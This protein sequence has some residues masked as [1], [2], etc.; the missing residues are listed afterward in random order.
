MPGAMRDASG[1]MGFGVLRYSPNPIVCVIDPEHVGLDAKDVTGIPRSCPV[2]ATVDDACRLGA[3]VFLLGIAPPGG[4]IPADWYREINQAWD[5]GMSIINGLHDR[6]APRFSETGGESNQW[7]WDI[8]TE[9]EGL[10]PNTGAAAGLAPKRVL[11]IGTDMAVGK[12]TAGLE[13][14]AEARKQ[15]VKA[16]FVATGQIGI[17][18]M[19]SGVPLDAIRVDFASGS[20]EGEMMRYPD[21]D[22]I[23]VEGQ[24]SLI[25]P[26]SSATLPLIR[27]S[28]P[29]HLILCAR[30]GQTHLARNDS[31]KIPPLREF[32]TMYEDLAEACNTFARPKTIAIA[33][34]CGHL[35]DAEADR[36]T[37]EI[38]AETGLPTTD[39]VR[40]GAGRLLEALQD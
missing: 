24:G 30:A 21:A 37:Q 13:L 9:P 1:K 29:T 39:P 36:A 28:M 16:E 15:N 18:I 4:L 31:I 11:F 10:K 32:I 34:N 5:E 17:T 3:D 33:L 20:I 6:L 23:L 2:V 22:M 12:M 38:E 40:H 19:G 25:H 8:R 7:V 27:G 26:G 14:W 35:N